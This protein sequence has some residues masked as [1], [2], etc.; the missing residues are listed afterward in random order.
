M[1]RRKPVAD[2]WQQP[3]NPYTFAYALG[4]T[5]EWEPDQGE[6]TCL[7]Q[8]D[9]LPCRIYADHLDMELYARHPDAETTE[10]GSNVYRFD[11]PATVGEWFAHLC[12][13]EHIW[14]DDEKDRAEFLEMYRQG[15][16]DYRVDVLKRLFMALGD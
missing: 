8:G 7:M 5:R 14:T 15:A 4:Y 10:Y 2:P 16:I 6:Q 12:V 11:L 3:V 9:W 1:P 13:V